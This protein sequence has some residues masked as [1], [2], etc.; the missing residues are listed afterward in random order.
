M[1]I[2]CVTLDGEFSHYRL[3][4]HVPELANAPKWALACEGLVCTDCTWDDYFGRPEFD[5]EDEEYIERLATL[6]ETLYQNSPGDVADPALMGA[7]LS[8]LAQEWG[9][10][11]AAAEE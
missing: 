3:Y 9:W 6:C 4:W 8:A 5:E 7:E 10:L 1:G 11:P 2:R